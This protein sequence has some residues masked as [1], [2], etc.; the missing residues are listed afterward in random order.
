[1]KMVGPFH[2]TKASWLLG[3]WFRAVIYMLLAGL[4][5][6]SYFG[7]SAREEKS[8]EYLSEQFNGNVDS[9]YRDERNHNVQMEI[10]STG[11]LFSTPAGW[12]SKIAV[13]DSMAKS[14]GSLK[15]YLY[16][17][18]KDTVVLDYNEVLPPK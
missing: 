13:G 14:K 4:L 18:A 2:E 6:W 10:L 3:F 5:I 7:P 15:I 8:K 1:M 9:I 17:K 16:K 12:E 11:W